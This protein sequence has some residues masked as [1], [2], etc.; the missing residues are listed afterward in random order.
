MNK[1]DHPV[2]DNLEVKIKIYDPRKL[3]NI[4]DED[5]LVNWEE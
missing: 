3:R 5:K 2:E 4:N 1:V